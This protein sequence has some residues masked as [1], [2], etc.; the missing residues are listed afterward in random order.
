MLIFGGQAGFEGDS[1]STFYIY[2]Q[3]DNFII[4]NFNVPT[5]IIDCIVGQLG[6]TL[7]ILVTEG[8]QDQN[9]GM[10]LVK[11]DLK[12]FSFG[13]VVI[14]SSSFTSANLTWMRDRLPGVQPPGSD[15]IIVS[16]F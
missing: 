10:K 13:Q 14:P 7:Y 16:I 2:N 12:T 8:D 4:P 6:T 9:R 11:F 1:T 5:K 3:R 15:A